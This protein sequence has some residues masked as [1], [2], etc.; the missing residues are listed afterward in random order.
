MRR[1]PHWIFG[2]LLLASCQRLERARECRAIAES[3][4]PELRQM[5]QLFGKQG[6]TSSEGFRAASTEYRRAAEA[7]SKLSLR[8]VE[9]ARLTREL[10]EQLLATS[11]SCDRFAVSSRD[12]GL[13]PTAARDFESLSTRHR[14]LVNQIDRRCAE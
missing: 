10:R 5:A 14:A 4:N 9:L 6:P 8:D 7:A 1:A 2:L 11:R 12:H 3:V 13:D